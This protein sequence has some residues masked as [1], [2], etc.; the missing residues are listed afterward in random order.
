MHHVV[1]AR[2]EILELPV[3]QLLWRHPALVADKVP[4]AGFKGHHQGIVTE[5]IALLN[6]I[7]GLLSEFGIALPLKDEVMRRQAREDLDFISSFVI[8]VV[9]DLL[10]QMS[11]LRSEELTP[12]GGT[13]ADPIVPRNLL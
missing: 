1:H 13:P 2:N 9:G 7:R 3:N 11:H 4:G 12:V 5:R 10:S 8:L 6:G